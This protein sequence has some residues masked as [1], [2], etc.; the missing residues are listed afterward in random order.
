MKTGQAN[1]DVVDQVE[2]DYLRRTPTSMALYQKALKA[3]PGGDTRTVSYFP[4][5]P[6]FVDR[7]K[8]CY[9]N[10]VD[11]NEYL[12]LVN[13]YTAL[14]H[15]HA[16]PKITYAVIEQLVK[17]T[18]YA[19]PFAEQIELAQV[20]SARVPSLEQVRFCNSGTEATMFALRA[21]KAFT[22]RNK[23]IKMEG[24]YHGSHDVAEISVAPPIES[25]G[26]AD[27]PYSVPGGPGLFKGVLADVVVAPFN[28]VEATSGI[29]KR[30]QND[31]AA[32]IVEPMIGSAGIIPAQP[33]YLRFLRK[34]TESCGALL[35]FDEVVSFRLD[36]A[37]A[38]EI[39]GVK[40][41][42]TTLGKVIGGGFPVGAFGGAADVMAQFDPRNGRLHH[43]GTFNGNAISVV[44]GLVSLELL[45]RDEIRR[46][47]KLGEHLRTRLREVFSVVGVTG[48]VTGIGSLTG[49]HFAETEVLDYRSSARMK[50]SLLHILHLSL[51]NQGIFAAPRGDF[52]LSTPMSEKEIDRLVNGF[53]R[54]L[55]DIKSFLATAD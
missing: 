23:I 1:V 28:D 46:I 36:Y 42:L 52:Y 12:D 20:L 15:G 49:V 33:E 29:V 30:C 6:L 54:A 21:A 45:T 55:I 27:A 22:G 18:I 41:D 40:P 24:G 35:I 32:V 17:G 9:V 10:D 8:G 7:G 16:H 37:G 13:N 3:M 2:S 38:Q 53:H 14:I 39:Y 34:I 50:K 44:A 5:Y 26:P 48:Q 47:N 19:T 31:L 4:P 51:L 43:S 25:A 11:G